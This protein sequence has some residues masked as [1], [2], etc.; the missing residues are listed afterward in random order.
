LLRLQLA[1]F[2]FNLTE[3]ATWLAVLVY[4]YRHGG[5]TEAG[6]VAVV[7]IAPATVGG[8]V[9]AVIADRGPP[10]RAIRHGYTAQAAILALV[11]VVLIG[12]GP[13][14]LVYA[15][16]AAACGALTVTRPAQTA[17]VPSLAR[18]PEELTAWNVLSGWNESVA[19]LAAPALAGLVL[20]VSGPGWVFAAAAAAM[21]L[22]AL[23][24]L[25]LEQPAGDVEEGLDLLPGE[26]PGWFAALQEGIGV[27][28]HER[29]ARTL[30]VLVAAQLAALGA[31]DIVTVGVAI[32]LLHLGRGGPG[33]LT[34]FFG[35]GAVVAIVVTA[36]FVGRKRLVP[37]LVVAAVAWGTAFL[38][39]GLRA[40]VV[41]ALTLLALA[42]AAYMSFDVASRTLLQRACPSDV[43][44]RLFGL[45]E[46]VGALGVAAGS[47]AVPLVASTLGWRAAVIGTGLLL[48][49]A[50]LLC[51]RSLVTVDEHATVPVVEIA[52]LRSV[53]FLQP[54][55]APELERL[56]RSLIPLEVD[57]GRVITAEG[58]VGDR[59]YVVAEGEVDATS[60]GVPL[61]R[62]RRGDGFGEIALL[63]DVPRTATCV[64]AG[65]VR[66][67][68]LEREPFLAAVTGDRRS[69]HV[70]GR[71][72]E[73]R[74][75]STPG[76]MPTA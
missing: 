31:L 30:L 16:A 42:G 27:L 8:P 14:F 34:A 75:Q 71:L 38:V 33:Y 26:S 6:L 70:A 62:L 68:A 10:A 29:A 12:G 36:T 74:L 2:G 45:I 65:R 21:L 37:P 3:W 56:A 35:V 69:L 20:A 48:P 73:R 52:L 4:A 49:A 59:F 40:S 43:V 11:A 44:A 39:L 63:R 28:R 61:R 15:F 67:Y 18:T 41:G 7:L 58:D 55:P 66:L 17:L 53:S 23:L 50:I 9:L 19:M 1:F 72:V 51:G 57:P 54:L 13:R 76:A 64:A 46:G 24:V 22:S 47:L 25:P 60:A 5:A 32:S